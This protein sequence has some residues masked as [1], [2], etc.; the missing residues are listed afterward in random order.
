MFGGGRRTRSGFGAEEEPLL[1]RTLGE[2]RAD[3]PLFR[4]GEL[5]YSRLRGGVAGLLVRGTDDI[6][7]GAQAGHE[8]AV[9]RLCTGQKGYTHAGVASIAAG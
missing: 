6:E 9:P 2:M 4:G 7:T 3:D 8:V 1:I 5:L